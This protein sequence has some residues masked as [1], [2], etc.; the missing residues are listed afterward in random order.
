MCHFPQSSSLFCSV[1]LM[2]TLVFQEK[3]DPDMDGSPRGS[4]D[5]PQRPKVCCHGGLGTIEVL[6]IGGLLC[7][8]AELE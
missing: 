1:V 7:L 4:A 5:I 2:G 8:F 3:L 6:I